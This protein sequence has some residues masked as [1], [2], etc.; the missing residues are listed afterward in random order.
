MNNAT[1]TKP[2]SARIE[3]MTPEG[4]IA[5]HVERAERDALDATIAKLTLAVAS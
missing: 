2:L 5:W 3:R 4:R 1:N